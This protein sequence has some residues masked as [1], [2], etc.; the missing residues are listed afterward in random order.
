M[1]DRSRGSPALEK[2]FKKFFKTEFAGVLVTDF[3]S[4]YNAVVCA[5]KQKCLPHLLR[6]L[7]RT[8]HDHQPGGA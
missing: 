4:A 1:I 2:F 5:Q 7:K 6:D 8:Q 3:W